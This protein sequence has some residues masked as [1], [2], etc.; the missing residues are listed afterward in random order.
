MLGVLG[1]SR[2]AL[3]ALLPSAMVDTSSLLLPLAAP[4]LC[5]A[6]LCPSSGG[7]GADLCIRAAH[8]GSL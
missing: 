2:A 6:M 3:H 5:D 8:L 7:C 4:L 1:Q